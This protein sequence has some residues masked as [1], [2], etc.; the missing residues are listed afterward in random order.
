[1]VT[2]EGPGEAEVRQGG[3]ELGQSSHGGVGEA[4]SFPPQPKGPLH[5]TGFHLTQ[6]SSGEVLS[7]GCKNW[8]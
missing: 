5:L 8:K 1:M 3:V 6:S 4:V 2:E 7:W